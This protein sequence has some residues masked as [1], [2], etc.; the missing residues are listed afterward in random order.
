MA[1]IRKRNDHGG[2]SRPVLTV[3][4]HPCDQKFGLTP[5]ESAITALIVRGCTCKD[6]SKQLGVSLRSL[7]LHVT[8]I[9]DKLGVSNRLE[10]IL[11][12]LFHHL[13]DTPQ[14]SRNQRKT[15]RTK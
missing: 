15:S 13:V 7:Q 6:V 2:E 11:F 10:L 12:S 9:L 8:E 3:E 4:G 5:L 14:L 1:K